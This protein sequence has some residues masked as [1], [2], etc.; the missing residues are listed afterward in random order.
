VNHDNIGKMAMVIIT[1][2]M[3]AKMTMMVKETPTAQTVKNA[4]KEF[5][6]NVT[7]NGLQ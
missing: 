2:T 6:N 4:T 5:S 1:M 3:T 7:I